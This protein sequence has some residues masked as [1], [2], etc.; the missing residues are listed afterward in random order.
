MKTEKIDSECFTTERKQLLPQGWSRQLKVVGNLAVLPLSCAKCSRRAWPTTRQRDNVR[1]SAPIEL[2]SCKQLGLRTYFLL[3]ALTVFKATVT[4]RA[5]C[6][7]KSRLHATHTET[8]CRRSESSLEFS[9]C[10]AFT[11]SIALSSHHCMLIRPQ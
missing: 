6:C 2:V 3:V 8:W 4:S 11:K 9:Q 10:P 1:L 5:C 7:R